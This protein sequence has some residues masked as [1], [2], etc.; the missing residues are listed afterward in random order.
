MPVIP[1]QLFAR[2]LISERGEARI[3]S[4]VFVLEGA[5]V[6]VIRPQFRWVEMT[7]IER[8]AHTAYV[9]PIQQCDWTAFYV[10]QL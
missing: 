7:N 10:D 6:P 2:R 9:D 8:G 5:P 4:Y 3:A 1:S